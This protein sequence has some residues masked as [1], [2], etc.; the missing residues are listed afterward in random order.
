MDIHAPSSGYPSSILSLFFHSN[1]DTRQKLS[2]DE[3]NLFSNSP[4][5]TRGAEIEFGRGIVLYGS[6]D[7][8]ELIARCAE[9]LKQPLSDPFTKEEF[10]GPK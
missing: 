8:D 10:F 3:F 6:N 4:I 5:G 7:P 2:Q 9:D 1:F